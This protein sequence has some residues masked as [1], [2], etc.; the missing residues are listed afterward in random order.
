MNILKK[1]IAPI[2]DKAWGEILEQTEEIFKTWLTAREVVDIDGPNGIDFGAVST[3][4]LKIPANQKKDGINY[5]IREVIPLIEVRKPFELDLWELDNVNRGLKDVDLEP[6]EDA[7]KEL[8]RFEEDAIY[9]GFSNGEISGLEKFAGD[10]ISI[11]DDPNDFL[12][13][14]AK[15]VIKF[16]KDG[17]SGPYSL[18]INERK[19]EV[20]L[21]LSR[22]YP[23]L[24]Q[25][26]ETLGGKII[27]AL[28]NKNSFLISE[29]GG[30]FEL[31]L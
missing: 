26:K 13:E 1:E 10:K 28:N 18:V 7:A 27:V 17:I 25:L 20:L 29:R 19:W 9:K 11:G 30:D 31:V 12:E 22:N 21:N 15:Q 23:I 5:G 16:K 14:I 3:G 6:L 4:R 24:N 8:A 2:T